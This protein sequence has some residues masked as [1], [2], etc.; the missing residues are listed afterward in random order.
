M[1]QSSCGEKREIDAIVRCVVRIPDNPDE[2]NNKTVGINDGR[3]GFGLDLCC[4]GRKREESKRL[5]QD[6]WHSWSPCLPTLVCETSSA[7]PGPRVASSLHG[8]SRPRR[9]RWRP[10]A[11]AAHR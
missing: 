2:R 9:G 11:D 5:E 10:A 3:H 6:D 7:A 1:L 8:S 4:P